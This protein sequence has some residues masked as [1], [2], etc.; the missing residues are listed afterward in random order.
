MVGWFSSA[1]VAATDNYARTQA[2]EALSKQCVVCRGSGVD[3]STIDADGGN[4]DGDK[5]QDCGGSGLSLEARN[6]RQVKFAHEDELPASA[7]LHDVFDGMHKA[8]QLGLDGKGGVRVYPYVEKNG[9][10]FYLVKL[11]Q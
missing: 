8:S 2:R 1:M 4:P 10:R 5:C 6:T 7:D 3:Q 9:Q 11:E